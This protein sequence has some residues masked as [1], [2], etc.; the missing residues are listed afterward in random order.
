[1]PGTG[2]SFH[3]HSA[4]ICPILLLKTEAPQRLSGLLKVMQQVG[5]A[6]G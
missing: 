2:L 4:L 6:L 3:L 5:D 1:M